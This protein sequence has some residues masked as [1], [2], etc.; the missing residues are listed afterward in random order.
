VRFTISHERAPLQADV[1]HLCVLRGGMQVVS[2]A[3]LQGDARNGTCKA[4]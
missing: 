1:Q 2:D 4:L 3:A